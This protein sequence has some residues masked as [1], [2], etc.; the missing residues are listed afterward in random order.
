MGLSTGELILIG[1]IV[2]LVFGWAGL[3]RLGERVGDFLYGLRRGLREDDERIVVKPKSK[4]NLP[5][6]PR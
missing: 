3:P 6:D 1:M 5:P 4:P 2:F